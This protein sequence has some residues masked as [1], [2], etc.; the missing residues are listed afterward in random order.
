FNTH[1]HVVQPSGNQEC[2]VRVGTANLGEELEAADAGHLKIGDYGIE[3]LALRSY[4]GFVTSRGGAAAV[5]WGPQ[6]YGKKFRGCAFVVDGENADN[7]GA[8]AC[9][10]SDNGFLLLG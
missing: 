7:G 8:L 5:R 4:K 3:W 9:A 2:N 6:H 1:F 10:S